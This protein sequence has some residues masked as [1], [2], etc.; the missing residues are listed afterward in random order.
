[1]PCLR[2]LLLSGASVY[3]VSL[4]SGC[5]TGNGGQYYRPRCAPL[6]WPSYVGPALSFCQL[7]ALGCTRVSIVQKDG[8]SLGR[9]HSIPYLPTGFS[10]SF[11]QLDASGCTGV[12]IVKKDP[13]PL[14]ARTQFLIFRPGSCR[15]CSALGPLPPLGGGFSRSCFLAPPLC[16]LSVL[17]IRTPS[18]SSI[19]L[20]LPNPLLE[21]S[22]IARPASPSSWLVSDPPPGSDSLSEASITLVGCPSVVPSKQ[23]PSSPHFVWSPPLLLS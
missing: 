7:D 20:S 13:P 1:M 8:G 9:L 14:A 17:Y 15:I 12:S 2:S 21:M 23:K 5:R 11:C 10:P 18:F 3:R 6:P 22:S 19:S 4:Y 16:G